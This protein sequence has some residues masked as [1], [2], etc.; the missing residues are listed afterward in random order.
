MSYLVNRGIV[1]SEAGIPELPRWFSDGRLSFQYDGNSVTQVDYRSKY[2]TRGSHT[3][4]LQR[5]WDGFRYY[6]EQGG[7]TLK[8]KYGRTTLW[9]CGV[10]SE[11]KL[12][13]DAKVTHLVFAAGE[14]IIFQVT[15]G[16]ELPE[17][18]KFK[19]EFYKDFGL[20]TDDLQDL[21]YGDRGSRRHWRD[22]EFAA[23][24]NMLL[25]SMRDVPREQP[26][27]G[28]EINL[29]NMDI[30]REEDQTPSELFVAVGADFQLQ[31]QERSIHT[32][33]ILTSQSAL[34]PNRSYSFVIGFAHTEGLAVETV[35]RL[36][37]DVGVVLEGQLK[38]Y[39]QVSNTS[40][41]LVSPYKDLNDFISLAPM[42]HESCK[43]LETPGA[44]KAKN[45]NYWVW[46]WDGMTSNLASLYW[47]DQRFIRD[48]LRFYEET[49]DAEYGIGHSFRHDMSLA[50]VSA[51]PAQS[52]YITLLHQY[53]TITG[54]LGELRAR[55][56][57]AR[58]VYERILKM[59]VQG[60]G[61][62]KG[63]S[64]FPDFPM[65]M[66]ETGDDIS[67]LN[68]TI[69][70][71]A[72][73]SMEMIAE[74]LNEQETR[75]LADSVNR[76][77]EKHY[78]PLFFDEQ[79]GFVVSSVDA[80]TLERRSSYNSNA[81]K[82]E[83]FFCGELMAGVNE[84]A[85]RFFEQNIVCKAG[86]REIPV[87]SEAFDMDANQLHCWLPVTGE[88]FMHLINGQ[89]R[90]DLIDQW[91]GWVSY[92]TKKLTCP[93]GISCYLDTDEPE[94]DR[95][96]TT[97]G[98]WHAYS[99]R[100][101]YQAAI[102]GVVGVGMEAGGLTFYPYDGEEMRLE[103]LHYRGRRF[104]IELRGSGCYVDAIEVDGKR[105]E[106]TNKLPEDGYGAGAIGADVSV[107]VHRVKERKYPV[108]VK[109]GYGITMTSYSFKQGEI[110]AELQ[111]A[112]TC[113]LVL[114]AAHLPIV[115]LN[116]ESAKVVYEETAGVATVE[117]RMT[118]GEPVKLVVS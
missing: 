27:K 20:I 19:L 89:N 87:W 78:L 114:E 9:P 75:A 109:H 37:A 55:F 91:V 25:G 116:D 22:F 6:L 72:S 88:Y 100:G 56:A 102:H 48:M 111:G 81:V 5:L 45:T 30:E 63:A 106:G 26:V 8:P 33:Y 113:R 62:S 65:Y 23:D 115:L 117:L 32:K 28:N 1:E 74:L 118:A 61:L 35:G 92:W 18:Y 105:V 97:K 15:T 46:G 93:E 58:S 4:F 107:V 36:S 82:W 79:R 34:V 31:Y 103:G 110:R 80:V 64:L 95:W 54:E 85:L 84:Q 7:V 108:S 17:G 86:L 21:R 99:I 10:E 47:G 94:V 76:N 39:E 50:S 40:P 51:L 60:L 66:Q 71:C 29:N 112:G 14:A 101:W 41:V 77:I 13:G 98:T 42:Y 53:Y 11:W 49:A 16:V 43:V 70:Y 104:N 59:E 44:I 24:S 2:Q 69:F 57:F 12:D 96:N 67:S 3:I 52:M 90:K 38:R 73:R 83:N 68:N